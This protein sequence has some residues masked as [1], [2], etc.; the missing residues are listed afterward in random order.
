MT[1]TSDP[2]PRAQTPKKY[3]RRRF[4]SVRSIGALVLR[5][6]SSSYGRS[7]GGYIWAILEP[8]A[9]IA[10]L[11]LVFSA[12]F[13]SPPM[14]ISFPLFYATGII[15][16]MVFME[17]Q[18]KLSQALN[19][20]RQLLAY[21]SVT[22]LDALAGRFILNL[23]TQLMVGYVL[24]TIVYFLFENRA[25]P[26]LPLIA[27]TYAYT[28]LLALGFGTMNCYLIVR[29]PIWQ[30]AWS[31]LTRPLFLIS[32]VFILFETIPEPYREWL[33]WNPLIHVIGMM[34]VAFYPTYDAGYVSPLYLILLSLG[35]LAGGLLLLRKNYRDLLQL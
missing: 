11:T 28:A 14:G 23:L 13:H 1:S 27:S 16:F 8:A 31:I 7:P 6:M 12:A 9:G 33:W 22:Y 32:G 3:K 35:L 24:L 26:N 19:Y 4:A 17:I 18:G 30:Q 21:P 20:S 29:F 15:P 34:R 5:E 2:V 10:L 25:T